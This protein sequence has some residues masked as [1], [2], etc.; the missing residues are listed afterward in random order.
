MKPEEL[1][2]RL[3]R[4]E[5]EQESGVDTLAGAP[6]AEPVLLAPL[7]PELEARIA[8]AAS[9]EVSP[10]PRALRRG[11][12]IAASAAAAAAIAGFGLYLSQGTGAELPAYRLAVSG[13]EQTHRAQGA[14][15]EVLE[16]RAGSRVVF[17]L[18]PATVSRAAVKVETFVL[19]GGVLSDWRAQVETSAEGAVRVEA[20]LEGAL[21]ERT[22]DLELIVA[23]TRAGR[24]VVDRRAIERSS[25]GPHA[26]GA[27]I[28]RVPARVRSAP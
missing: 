27:R 20:E 16:V 4:L 15:A 2:Q 24:A 17:E 3:A 13:G 12:W 11:R 14:E 25:D 21:V 18:T 23:I 26:E 22:G 28:F 7:S 9:A 5:K 19:R 10:A 8:A 1:L 6:E